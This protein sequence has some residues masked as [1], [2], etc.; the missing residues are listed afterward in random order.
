MMN[1]VLQKLYSERLMTAAEAVQCVKSGDTVYVGTASST[2]F[3]LLDALGDRESEL[4]QV[5]LT[6]SGI[7]VSAKVASG[8][9]GAFTS[10]TYFMGAGERHMNATGKGDFYSVHLSQVDRFFRDVRPAGIAFLEVTP[11]DHNGY[12]NFGPSGVAVN[13]HV[14]ETA[15]QVFVQVNR[16]TPWVYGEHNCIHISQVNGIVEQDHDMIVTPDLPSSPEA[17]AISRFLVDQIP[18]GACIQTGIGGLANAVAFGLK[19]K[20]DL[21]VHTEVIVNSVMDLMKSGVVNNSRKTIYRGKT[22]A[23]FSVGTQ[24]LFA[25]LDHNPNLYYLPFTVVNDPRVIAQ[26]DQMISVNTAMAVDLFGQVV[27]DNIA[28]RQYSC[29]G[30]QLDFV[31]GAQMSKGGKSFIAMT[32]TFLD[33]TGVLHSRIVPS[34]AP[35]TAITTPRSDVQY[36]VTEYGCVNLK[37]LSH[38]GRVQALISLAHPDFRPELTE[39]ARKANLIS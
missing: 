6:A 29:T 10:C 1:D 20:N 28:G 27:A 8:K 34:F 17:D 36:M 7:P 14:L 5:C 11:P 2:P 24:E 31:R 39:A 12:M 15:K 19:D 32:A 3:A 21:G 30:G 23:G 4:E 33:K 35:G 9:T 38:R 13:R 16:K 26:N 18:D 22:V 37:S 25:F